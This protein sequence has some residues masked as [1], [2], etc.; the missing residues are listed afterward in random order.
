MPPLVVRRIT[1]GAV[2]VW[3]A[4]LANRARFGDTRAYAQTLPPPDV[5]YVNVPQELVS[6]PAEAFSGSL[7]KEASSVLALGPLV[8]NKH[9]N[10]LFV[11]VRTHMLGDGQAS[12]LLA[13]AKED[14]KIVRGGTLSTSQPA[15]RTWYA[16]LLLLRNGFRADEALSTATIPPPNS[17][18]AAQSAS[19]TFTYSAG[20]FNPEEHLTYVRKLRDVHRA[21]STAFSDELDAVAA[22]LERDRD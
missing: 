6:V 10:V 2:D 15:C 11:H 5:V 17:G 8:R 9:R 22:Y 7:G 1:D 12:R 16:S 19:I 20:D 18:I 4:Y 14:L 21:R 13:A 3:D